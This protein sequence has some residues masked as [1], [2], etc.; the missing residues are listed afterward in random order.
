MG[1]KN[2]TQLSNL[3]DLRKF[4]AKLVNQRLR[5]DVDSS[6]ARDVGYLC[7]L[8]MEILDRNELERRLEKLELLMEQKED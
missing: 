1:R 8:L 4:I 5:G 2:Y 6:T 3:S 7:K